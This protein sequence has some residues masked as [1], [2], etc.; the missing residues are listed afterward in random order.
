MSMSTQSSADVPPNSAS[1]IRHCADFPPSIW[2]NYFLT[3]PSE[4]I[5]TTTKEKHK[6]LKEEVRRK[7]TATVI[8]KCTQKSLLQLI[9]AVQRLAV[10]YHFEKEIEDALVKIFEKNIDDGDDDLYTVSLRFRLLRQQGLMISCDIFNKFKDE[11][12]KFFKESLKKDVEG[13]RSLYEAAHLSIRGEEILDE[14]LAFTK[15]LL[16][17]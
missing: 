2:G 12:G 15:V 7:I 14:A 10:A 13:I 17:Q 11:E 3:C 8:D 16:L 9:D 1:E 5:D 4:I 6:A